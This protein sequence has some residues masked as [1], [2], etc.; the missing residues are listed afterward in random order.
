MSRYSPSPPTKN[1]FNPPPESSSSGGRYKNYYLRY[2]DL[3]WGRM[4]DYFKNATTAVEGTGLGPNGSCRIAPILPLTDATTVAGRSALKTAINNMLERYGTNVPEGMAWGWRV[5]SHG[6]PFTEGRP[7]DE[8][9]ND[10]VVIVLT[11]GANLYETGF[12]G[13]YGYAEQP[14]LPTGVPRLFMGTKLNPKDMSSYNTTAAMNQHFADLCKNAKLPR[15]S[16]DK[17][18]NVIVMTVALDLDSRDGVQMS[19]IKLLE[20]CASNSRIDPKRKMFWNA[21]GATLS[22]TFKDIADE[23]SNLRVVQ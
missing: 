20:D 1:G 8:R 7:D 14:Y 13:A 3:A 6:E 12:R 19:Q 23:L 18:S 21:T 11:D 22:A 9:G 15:S 10:K 2:W 16:T 5:L 17:R 4:V